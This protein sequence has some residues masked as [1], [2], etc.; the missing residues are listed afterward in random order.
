M[1]D[2]EFQNGLQSMVE[3]LLNFRLIQDRGR[4]RWL[5][6]EI[7]NQLRLLLTD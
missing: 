2:E 5:K 3:M 1:T 6:A 7:R 4:R